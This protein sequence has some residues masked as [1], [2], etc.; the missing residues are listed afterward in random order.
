MFVIMKYLVYIVFF[1]LVTLFISK[2]SFAQDKRSQWLVDQIFRY[3]TDLDNTKSRI[4][5]LDDEINRNDASISKSE[6]IISMAQQ[7]GNTQA[8]TVGQ[9]ALQKAKDAKYKN[10]DTRSKAYS[11]L[12]KLN[13]FLDY[14]KT[15]PADAEM[16]SE[17]FKYDCKNDEWVK[18]ND[19]NIRKRLEKPD[20]YISDLA[21]SIKTKTPPPITQGKLFDSLEPGDIVLVGNEGWNPITPV[22]NWFSNTNKSEAS[23]TL[24]YLKEINGKKMFLDSQPGTGP[25]IITEDEF[26]KKYGKRP[27]DVAHLLT[28]PVKPEDG[29]KLY[30]NAFELVADNQKYKHDNPYLIFTGTKYGAWGEQNM[31]CSEADRWVLMKSG[32][33]IPESEDF[34]KKYLGVDYSPADY[35]KS[36]YFFVTPLKGVK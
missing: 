22:D 21:N 30:S 35:Y 26:V 1:A 18:E 10:I 29:D 20:P 23:H 27:S 4:A 33:N 7:K 9:Q 3:E 8:E 11:Y 16:K 14:L 24:I 25:K 31:V 15:N 36:C 17:Q 12:I 13:T 19:E 34:L 2:N 6:S 32:Y 5:L 28:Q